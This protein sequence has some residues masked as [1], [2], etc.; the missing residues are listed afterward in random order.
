[1]PRGDRSTQILE[2]VFDSVNNKLNTKSALD[3]V[4]EGGSLKAQVEVSEDVG[5]TTAGTKTGLTDTAKDWPVNIWAN[6]LLEM[7]IGNKHYFRIVTSNTATALVFPTLPGASA[8]SSIG[9]GGDGTITIG[10]VA[11]GTT[12]NAYTVQAVNGVGNNVELSAVLASSILTITLGTDAGGV[13]DNAKNTA[14]LVAAAI[15]ALA[16]FTATASGTGA[17]VLAAMGAPATFS[18]G[19][20]TVAPTGAAEY[21]LKK[22][23]GVSI[24]PVVISSNASSVSKSHTRPND[25]DPY[26]IGDVVGTNPA[27]NIEFENV[28]AISGSHAIIMGASLE[29]DVASIPAG[30]SSFRLHLYDSAPTAILDNAVFDLPSGDRSKYLGYIEISTPVDLGATLWSQIDNV[31]MKRKLASTSIFGMLE[32]R[33][34]YT[35]TASCVKKVTLHIVGV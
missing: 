6:A 20:D 23:I 35:P 5:T 1:M 24:S 22:P 8:S 33:G 16:E 28:V 17:T 31:N 27:T 13:P 34:A 18:G 14:T 25:S 32:T 12:G 7:T 30:M 11:E 19:V 3:A 2:S 9:A 21:K 10:V 26:G 15:D 4:L 29:V